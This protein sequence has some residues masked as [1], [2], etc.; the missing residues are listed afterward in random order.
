MPGNVTGGK[1]AAKTNKAKHGED[2]YKRIGR[3]GGKTPTDKPKGFA[4]N[5]TL[6]RIA[7]ARGGRI[8]RRGL[9]KQKDDI[10]QA[11]KI[12]EKEVGRD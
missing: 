3:L 12:L 9:A 6:A 4:A 2:F 11:E 5:P 8:S 1:R 7:G 10:D